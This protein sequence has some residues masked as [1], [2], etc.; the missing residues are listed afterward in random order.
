MFYLLN[1]Q[2]V[3]KYVRKVDLK[4]YRNYQNE[5]LENCLMYI[6]DGASVMGAS[7]KYNTSVNYL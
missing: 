4:P 1:F 5:S 3:Q 7:R 6:R 2:L